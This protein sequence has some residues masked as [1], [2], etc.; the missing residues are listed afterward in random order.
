MGMVGDLD[1]LWD[2]EHPGPTEK[3][4]RE[5]LP[6]A[7]DSLDISYLAEL[8]TQIARTEAMQ[9]KFSDARETLDRV[10]KALTKAD[11]RVSV[12]YVLDRGRVLS[13]SV[14]PREAQP[15]VRA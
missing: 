8:L 15:R 11:Q 4:F 7:L 2:Y 13:Q 9:K 10:K 5:L 6:A 1:S 12:R 14:K 3:K